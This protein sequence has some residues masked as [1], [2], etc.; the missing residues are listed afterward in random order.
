MKTRRDV[1]VDLRTEPQTNTDKQNQTAQCKDE[2]ISM[3]KFLVLTQLYT[4]LFLACGTRSMETHRN[5]PA[6]K[7]FIAKKHYG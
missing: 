4:Y 6:D 3:K 2:R 7:D 5:P 1:S